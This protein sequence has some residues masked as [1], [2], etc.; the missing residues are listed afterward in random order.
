MSDDAH[1]DV[2]TQ[3]G[4]RHD[5]AS[6]AFE[7][8][9]AFVQGVFMV[10]VGVLLALVVRR[11]VF[12]CFVV[13]T[14]SMLPTIQLDEQI[15]CEKVSYHVRDVAVGDIVCF[16]SDYNGGSVLVKR[17]IATGGQTVDVRDGHVYV[18]GELSEYGHGSTDQLGT[19]ISYP[20]TLAED[21][22][23]VMGDNREQ[24]SDSRVFGPIRVDAVIGHV[25]GVVWPPSRIE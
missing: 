6:V 9:G 11:Y 10:C 14:G 16:D 24:S 22:L 2:A 3:I 13:P 18:D 5:A 20:L 8:M 4:P 7:S 15:V 19:S 12:E 25:V 17:V 23:W 21:E 1:E